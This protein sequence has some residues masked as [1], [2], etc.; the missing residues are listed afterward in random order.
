MSCI[1]TL[2]L[3]VAGLTSC[4]SFLLSKLIWTT[5]QWIVFKGTPDLEAPVAL[6]WGGEW[7]FR[8]LPVIPNVPC[9]SVP[10][11]RMACELPFQARLFNFSLVMSGLQTQQAH[12]E[13]PWLQWQDRWYAFEEPVSQMNWDSDGHSWSLNGMTVPWPFS[14]EQTHQWC[15]LQIRQA[16]DWAFP[17]IP[18]CAYTLF[19][20]PFRDIEL[21]LWALDHW[22]DFQGHDF[23]TVEAPA[24][25]NN[26][27]MGVSEIRIFRT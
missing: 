17:N 21:S 26:G 20:S 4:A 5:H 22:I 18:G 13:F 11:H 14:H 2:V 6:L 12:F 27:S 15:E 3:I 9:A 10:T 1:S 16:T 7:A 8:R 19:A 23:V 25:F 24:L